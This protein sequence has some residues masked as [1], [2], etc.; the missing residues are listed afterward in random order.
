MAEL[1]PAGSGKCLAMFL[2]KDYL[3]HLQA[4]A[5]MAPAL[6]IHP[7]ISLAQQVA[8]LSRSAPACAGELPMTLWLKVS[9]LLGTLQEKTACTGVD[10]HANLTPVFHS[11]LTPPV[12]V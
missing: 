7:D 4:L 12:A 8:Y 11:I 1:M 6:R 10:F 2:P 9:D 5:S 3:E